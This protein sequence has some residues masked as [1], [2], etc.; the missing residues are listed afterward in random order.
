MRWRRHLMKTLGLVL[1]IGLLGAKAWACPAIEKIPDYNCDSAVKIAILGDSLVFGIGD[2]K[3]NNQGGY[4]LRLGHKFRTAAVVS[5]GF[6]GVTSGQLLLK[7]RRAFSGTSN[8]SLR[9]GILGSDIVILD[10]GRNDRWFFKPPIATYRNLKRIAK[11][12]QD[13]TKRKTGTASLVVMAVLMLPNRG[14]Q[15]PW[16]SE[17]N[18][19]ILH[20]HTAASPSNLRFDRV[21]K[22]L[23][24][25]DNIHP[26]PEGYDALAKVAYRYLTKVLPR[27]IS[28]LRPD[29]DQDGIYDIFEAPKFGTDPTKT[30]TDGD[31]KS[32]GY[33]VFTSQTDP[34][35]P[36]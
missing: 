8:Q 33:E 34:L 30:D 26:S 4:P 36:D 10:L 24:T 32:D 13:F 1:A 20:G 11:A 19:L 9:D 12:I 29:L 6:P 23:L 16:V 3:N 18:G 21:S 22:S 2:S 28:R 17:L 31:G 7:L 15:A 5:L 27:I 35:N 14:S 25:A